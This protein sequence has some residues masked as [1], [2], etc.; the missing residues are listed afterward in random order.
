M[1]GLYIL[2]STVNFNSNV[3]QSSYTEALSK[4]LSVSA[5]A[6]GWGV[7]DGGMF[8][9]SG[10][11]GYDT[12]NTEAHAGGTTTSGDTYSA[13]TTITMKGPSCVNAAS[14]RASLN[15]GNKSWCFVNNGLKLDPQ[16][17]DNVVNQI[18][19]VWELFE[20]AGRKEE[21]LFLRNTWLDIVVDTDAVIDPN[22]FFSKL[23]NKTLFVDSLSADEGKRDWTR[24]FASKLA[25]LRT[26]IS[27]FCH[28]EGVTPYSDGN[29]C[30]RDLSPHAVGFHDN[31]VLTRFHLGT[32]GDR[33]HYDYTVACLSGCGQF[34]TT[35]EVE[36]KTG[37]N[38]GE[39]EICCYLDRH[40]VMAPEGHVL[41]GFQL[42]RDGIQ[43]WIRYRYTQLF[44][45]DVKFTYRAS[46]NV[47]QQSGTGWNDGADK[48]MVYLD[49]QNVAVPDGHLMVGFHL[50][51]QGGNMRYDFWHV[52]ATALKPEV[53]FLGK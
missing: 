42:E 17:R 36:A 37:A 15:N 3:S 24:P 33:I 13:S 29:S 26:P 2:R 52:P 53:L 21:A 11:G 46:D 32:D 25:A 14:F 28:D 47:V 35:R 6:S 23:V 40:F 50:V 48:A 27:V 45:G 12:T 7:F 19:P 1:G 10:G 5:G 16:N 34:L 39:N 41:T 49:R 4:T 22:S 38:K 51:D 30:L 31:R 20:R 43:V 44:A 9:A 8:G 18:V